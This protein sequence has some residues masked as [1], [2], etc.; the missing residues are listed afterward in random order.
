MELELV[1]AIMV[2][3]WNPKVFNPKWVKANLFSYK[4]N[5]E[6]NGLVNADEVEFGFQSD[7]VLL[8]VRQNTIEI[9]LNN[10][11]DES[12]M[13]KIPFIANKILTLLLHTPVK[14]V[15][16]NFKFKIGNDEHS[17]FTKFFRE[18]TDS[19][20]DMRVSQLRYQSKTEF[21]TINLIVEYLNNN[22]NM[23]SFNFHY[24]KPIIFDNTT[25]LNHFKF[26]T[27][28]INL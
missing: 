12:G 7:G 8:F 16:F 25:L 19:Y 6:V 24:P 4:E 23:T 2:G 26:S 28:K 1:N 11:K 14:G 3:S 10:P 5:L 17:D 27:Q 9:K 20:R 22:I 21:Y 13:E 18:K 15:G